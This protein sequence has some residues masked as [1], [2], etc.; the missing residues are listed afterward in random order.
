LV[1]GR[2]ADLGK[3]SAAPELRLDGGVEAI[4]AEGGSRL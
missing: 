2:P 4:W 1:R 3:P